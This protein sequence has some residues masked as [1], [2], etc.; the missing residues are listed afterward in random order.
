M[1]HGQ[2]LPTEILHRTHQGC[3]CAS[4]GSWGALGCLWVFGVFLGYFG[5][6]LRTVVDFGRPWCFNGVSL[7]FYSGL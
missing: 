4:G 5:V 2:N 6:I 3:Q 1:D 7:V